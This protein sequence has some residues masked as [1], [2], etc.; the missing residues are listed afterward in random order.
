MRIRTLQLLVTAVL[1]L[2]AI[3]AANASYPHS[4]CRWLG[5]GWSDGYHSHYGCPPKG[6]QLSRQ[7][8]GLPAMTPNTLQWW[9]G[10]SKSAEQVPTPAQTQPANDASVV[11]QGV[12]RR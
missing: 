3:G 9:I 2:M 8:A 7:A 10:P 11:G 6:H 1:I 12:I 4:C 5:T